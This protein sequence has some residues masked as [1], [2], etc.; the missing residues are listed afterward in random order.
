MGIGKL[1]TAEGEELITE[2]SYRLFQNEDAANWWG[3]LSLIDFSR[4]KDGDKYILEL[5]DN[6][7]GGCYLKKRVNRAVSGIPSRYVYH[8]TGFTP[9]E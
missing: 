5:E 4:L 1:Y 3:E 8:I 2:V 9:L 6:R 7:R